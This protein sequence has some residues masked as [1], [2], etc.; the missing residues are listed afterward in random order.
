[1]YQVGTGW[2]I[3]PCRKDDWVQP[4]ERGTPAQKTFLLEFLEQR[5]LLAQKEYGSAAGRKEAEAEWAGL[6][7]SLNNIRGGAQKTVVQW[8]KYWDDQRT[9]VKKRAARVRNHLAGTG[10]G[11]PL[12][13]LSDY[14]RR[15]LGLMGGWTRVVGFT[16][17]VDPLE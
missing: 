1:M 10:G 12:D 8:I 14:D 2:D 15:V 13:L 5:P 7:R 17:V 6:A 9:A 16:S 11:R 4:A 3:D